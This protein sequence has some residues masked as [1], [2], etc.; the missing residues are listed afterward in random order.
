EGAMTA[1]F[2]RNPRESVMRTLFVAGARM[3]FTI[4]RAGTSGYTRPNWRIGAQ[5]ADRVGNG[6][7]RCAPTPKFQIQPG[8]YPMSRSLNASLIA[9]AVFALGPIAAQ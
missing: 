2:L 4:A 5:R 3:L 6:L 8:R 9:A 1:N 7:G